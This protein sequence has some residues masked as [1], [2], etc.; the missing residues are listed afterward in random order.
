M[1]LTSRTATQILL[2]DTPPHSDAPPYQV[3]L[4]LMERFRRSGP[5]SVSDCWFRRYRLDKAGHTDRRTD[6]RQSNGPTD[7]VT[8]LYPH[9]LC[10]GEKGAGKGGGG[11]VKTKQNLQ[12]AIAAVILFVFTWVIVK[13]N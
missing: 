2:H 7:M 8:P 1:T 11:G 9:Q 5:R 10:Y 6:T 12:L 4:Q 13:C 3:W